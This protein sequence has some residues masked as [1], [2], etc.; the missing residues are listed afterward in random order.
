[1]LP[2][3]GAAAAVY[4]F[5]LLFCVIILS[6]PTIGIR[7][8]IDPPRSHATAAWASTAWSRALTSKWLMRPSE[9][10]APARKKDAGMVYVT[11]IPLSRGYTFTRE[12]SMAPISDLWTRWT[13]VARPLWDGARHPVMCYGDFVG[14]PWGCSGLGPAS[15]V[16]VSQSLEAP[17]VCSASGSFRMNASIS[18]RTRR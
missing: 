14:V 18:S 7:Y 12:S 1:M 4:G 2:P 15:D 16:S 3:P 11:R 13:V 17:F 8:G 5:V 9:W 10:L 6:L